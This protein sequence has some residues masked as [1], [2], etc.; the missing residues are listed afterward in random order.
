MGNSGNNQEKNIRE[1]KKQ[2]EEKRKTG[3]LEYSW[4]K[5]A[6]AFVIADILI[7]AFSYFAALMIRLILYFPALTGNMSWVMYGQCHIGSSHPS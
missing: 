5:K 4:L 2:E 1:K 6:M 3:M 7:I